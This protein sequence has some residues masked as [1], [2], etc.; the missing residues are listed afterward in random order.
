MRTPT[1]R[2]F[3]LIFLAASIA[4][5]AAV[6]S[7]WPVS[8]PDTDAQVTFRV[9]IL[10]LQ[11]VHS[12]SPPSASASVP[13]PAPKPKPQAA[14]PLPQRTVAVQ[15]AIPEPA[16]RAA[17]TEPPLPAPAAAEVARSA[18]KETAVAV[19][20]KAEPGPPPGAPLASSDAAYL[21]NAL[22]YP[23]ASIRNNE[24][25]TVLL[26]V[27]VARDGTVI[28]AELEKSSGWPNLD[29]AAVKS[30]RTWR[31]TP[32]RRGDE[33]IEKEYLVPTVFRLENTRR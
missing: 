31:F 26:K 32:A 11:P 13:Q 7:W 20:R 33:A 3:F 16:T 23:V 18:D 22:A 14:R 2:R 5:H 25:G 12:T 6:L 4:M 24:Q 10:P 8:R 29:A 15:Q 17:R 28:R 9:E 1:D 30:V 19:E 27:L 21:R